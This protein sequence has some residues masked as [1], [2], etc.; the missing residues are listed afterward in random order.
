MLIAIAETRKTMP[1]ID[2]AIEAH[3]GF[4]GAFA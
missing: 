4:P 2:Q 1:E 3:D